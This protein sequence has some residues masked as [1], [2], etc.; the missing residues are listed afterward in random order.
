MSE[1]LV[2]ALQELAD[3]SLRSVASYTVDDY[4]VHHLRDDVEAAY[5]V[6]DIEAIHEHLAVDGLSKQRLESLFDA[7]DYRSSMHEFEDALVFHLTNDDSGLFVSIDR[8]ASIPL[9]TV[10]YRC[11]DQLV[12]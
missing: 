3:G 4:T 10:L 11:R 9:S 6:T 12:A 8:F 5:T 7:G 1:E 2:A